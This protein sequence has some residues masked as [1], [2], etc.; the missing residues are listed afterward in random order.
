MARPQNTFIVASVVLDRSILNRRAFSSPRKS[1]D[2]G[3]AVR[4]AMVEDAAF[5]TTIATELVDAFETMFAN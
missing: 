3:T 5:A 2:F 1:N 4:Q